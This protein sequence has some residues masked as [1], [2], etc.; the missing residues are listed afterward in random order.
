MFFDKT[1]KTYNETISRVAKKLEGNI[2]YWTRIRSTEQLF[3]LAENS[4]QLAHVGT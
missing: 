3:R 1:N 4:K 2:Y